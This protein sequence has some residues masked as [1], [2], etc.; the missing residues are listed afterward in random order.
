[1]EESHFR[2]F[3]AVQGVQQWKQTKPTAHKQNVCAHLPKC[4]VLDQAWNW[5]VML[6]CL[7]LFWK[8]TWLER[9]PRVPVVPPQEAGRT[10]RVMLYYFS[11]KL[12]EGKKKHRHVDPH[13][14]DPG[15]RVQETPGRSTKGTT[16]SPGPWKPLIAPLTLWPSEH[17]DTR[18]PHREA[19]LNTPSPPL[20]VHLS[21]SPFLPALAEGWR[22]WFWDQLSYFL[23]FLYSIHTGYHSKTKKV[24][25]VKSGGLAS[26][27]SFPSD[28][29][30][31]IDDVL[32]H[33]RDGGAGLLPLHRVQFQ[34][35]GS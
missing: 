33:Q 6:P 7:V 22:H 34:R 18:S 32:S 31:Q 23:G 21:F 30:L 8:V 15:W 14:L 28:L 20:T 25:K 9:E 19:T 3:E 24:T 4:R 13:L 1:M 5:S 10:H 11:P 35:W 29:C 17:S 2:L 16:A 12:S 27:P 26:P